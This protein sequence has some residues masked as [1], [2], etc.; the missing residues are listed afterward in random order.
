MIFGHTEDSQPDASRVGGVMLT[1]M[2]IKP[3]EIVDT[4]SMEQQIGF[5]RGNAVDYL[6]RSGAKDVQEEI[7]EDAKKAEHYCRK[8]VAVLSGGT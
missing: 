7:L 1:A 8:L 4:W 3:W 2:P 6:L 5:Y